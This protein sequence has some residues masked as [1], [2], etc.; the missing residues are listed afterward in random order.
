MM[1]YEW[2]KSR[3]NVIFSNT[4][5]ATFYNSIK[6]NFYLRYGLFF[7]SGSVMLFL[8]FFPRFELH[9]LDKRNLSQIP[10]DIFNAFHRPIFVTSLGL[11]L[12]GTMVGRMSFLRGAFGGKL[13]APWAKVTFTAYLLHTSVLALCFLQTKGAFYLTVESMIFYSYACFIV[14]CIL[15]VP[16]TLIIESPIL[17]LERLVIFPPQA[18]PVAEKGEVDHNLLSEAHQIN[19]SDLKETLSD[20]TLTSKGSKMKN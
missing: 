14:T 15:S 19:N 10:S 12:S 18:K 7:A 5:G 6:T 8:I 17:Q 16:L 11:F 20:M 4:F 9:N 2:M 1:Y 3:S 13:F